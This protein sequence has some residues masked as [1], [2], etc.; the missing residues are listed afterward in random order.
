MHLQWT[1]RMLAL[2]AG[3][4]TL[5]APL[6]QRGHEI[7]PDDLCFLQLG[8]DGDVQTWPGV[9]RIRLWEDARASLGFNGPGVAQEIYGYIVFYL[10]S[11]AAQSNMIPPPTASLS[12]PPRPD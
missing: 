5:V 11:S 2:R 3:K 8:T 10:C 12:A 1:R 4:S 6:A 9:R 7:I